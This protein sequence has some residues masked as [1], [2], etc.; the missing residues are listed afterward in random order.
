MSG[1]APRTC[2]RSPLNAR[3][4]WPVEIF[5]RAL[6][7]QNLVSVLSATNRERPRDVAELRLR[8]SPF[9]VARSRTDTSNAIFDVIHL[10]PMRAA[11]YLRVSSDRQDQANQELQVRALCTA[12]G[13]TVEPRHEF[14]VT[15]KGDAEKNPTKDACRDAARRGEIDVIVVWALDRWTRGG[16]ADLIKDVEQ[17][18]R[19]GVALVSVQEPWCDT[20]DDGT[21]E[22]LLAIAGWMGRR[23]KARLRER[24][25][26]TA[27]RLRADLARKGKLVSVR[28]GRIFTR[29]GRPSAEVSPK[30]LQLA[31]ELRALPGERFTSKPM[32]WPAVAARVRAELGEVVAPAT[33]ARLASKTSTHSD[34]TGAAQNAA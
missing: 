23:E 4:R 1:S 7:R 21:G 6:S 30:A 5:F 15:E 2:E 10:F 3:R 8:A 28:S 12:R 31:R 24:N 20:S 22:L 9:F 13:Y 11:I 32:G 17:L 25:K 27:Q 26:A 16:I 18:R 14:R 33:L 19:W 34:S 29:L